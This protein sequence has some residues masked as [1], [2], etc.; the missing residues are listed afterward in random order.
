[1]TISKADACYKSNSANASRFHKS[2]SSDRKL[3][4]R[5]TAVLGL[6]CLSFLLLASCGSGPGGITIEIN[7]GVSQ[8]IDQGQ[9]LL[10]TA[11]VGGDTKNLGVTWSLPTTN[12]ACSGAACGTLTGSSNFMVTYVGP[13]NLATALT[14]TVEATSIANTSVTKTITITVTLPPT[15]TTTGLTECTVNIFCLT[16]GSNGVPYTFSLIASG[17]VAPLTYTVPVNAL[18]AGLT[19]SVLGVITGRP[20]GPIQSQPNPVIFTVTITDSATIPLTVT[21]QF[22]I[23][24]TPASVLS[25][26]S[27]PT[28]PAGFINGHYGGGSTATGGVTI[29]TQGGV[30][31]FT[32]SLIS[33]ALPPGLN[34]GT[35]SGQITGIPSSLA[36]TATPYTFTV[37]VEDSSL[38][39]P[40]QI[41]QA[42]FSIQIQQPPT[43]SISTTSLPG[44]FTATG[45]NTALQATGGIPPYT[46]TLINGQLPA[47]L[48]FGSNGVIVGKPILA[49]TNPDTFTVEV[50]DSELNPATGAPQ[51]ASVTEPLAIS[52]AGGS[53]NN[54]LIVGSYSFLF[55]GFDSAGSVAIAGNIITNGNGTITAG[56]E[57][58]NRT[59][60]IIQ[61]ATITGTYSLG[62]DGRGTMEFIATNPLTK[63]TLTTD[64]QL[65]MESNGSIRFFENDTIDLTGTRG[66]GVMKPV[67]GPSTFTA[68]NF[69]GNYAFLF[70]GQDSSAMP[71]VLGGVINSNGSE[72][73]SGGIGDFNEAGTFSPAIDLSGAFSVGTTNRSAASLTYQLPQKSQATLS[74]VFYFV[75]QSDLYFVGIDPIDATHPRLSG[76]LVLQQPSVQFSTNS[77][78]GTSVVTGTGLTSGNSNVLAG[79]L[80]GS[81][82]SSGAV[83]AT[84]TYDENVGGTVTS[85]SPVFPCSGCVTP[86][87]TVATNGRV[88]FFNLAL[89]TAQ[90]RIAAAYLTAPGQGFFVGSDSAATSGLLEAQQQPLPPAVAFTTSNV[91]GGYTLGSPPAVENQ[92]P[93]VVGQLVADGVSSMT[94]LLDEIDPTTA[95]LGSSLVPSYT[96]GANGRGTMIANSLVGFPVNLALYIVSPGSVRLIGLDP[97]NANPYVIYLDH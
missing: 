2:S 75:S 88:T 59:S 71:T 3:A 65:V 34:L 28:L 48:T 73:L 70:T 77:L 93:N 43:L 21:Q 92:V 31:P 49:T 20:S 7:S 58:S 42:T 17:G 81:V 54:T 72:T 55:N 41:Q 78:T 13:T 9:S 62:S 66:T 52:V 45:Y 10:L 26:T 51:P 96:V 64:Y 37:Q 47:G 57:D 5:S 84:L 27:P 30:L 40:G 22:E 86:T 1:M 82:A 91:L 90:Q 87:Y 16:N 63:V 11:T 36:Q 74:Y 61:G 68:G 24:I 8:T 19:L 83:S 6:I 79:L 38:P 46:W 69:S 14:V 76:E 85:P 12:T 56:A 80:T 15:F 94:G 4:L 29:S 18:P 33:G 53:T 95:T 35:N 60:G 97:G 89:P 67:L 50:Q 39:S 32:W 25:I 44:G 23:S